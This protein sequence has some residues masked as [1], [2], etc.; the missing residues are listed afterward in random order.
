M[1]V[2]PVGCMLTD[3]TKL[4]KMILPVKGMSCAICANR[5][6][7]ALNQISG[8]IHASFNFATEKASVGYISGQIC[9]EDL[10]RAIEFSGHS[11]PKI[12]ASNGHIR[13]KRIAGR[14][15]SS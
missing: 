11:V 9:V 7:K 2:N 5:V 3:D 14:S 8:V 15:S 6:Q 1:Q 12:D 4:L 13:K 10:V